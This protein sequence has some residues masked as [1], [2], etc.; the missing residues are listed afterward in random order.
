MYREL[1]PYSY[2]DKYDKDGNI[3]GGTKWT[4]TSRPVKTVDLS[5]IITKGISW[6]S[7]EAGE[8]TVTRWLDENGK[9]TTDPTKAFDGEYYDA[10][11]N[12]W[13][14]LGRNACAL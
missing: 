1:N 3:I 13:Q 10:T 12:S 4:P 11:T 6:A 8:S 9:L 7:A 2:Q 14:R 5:D